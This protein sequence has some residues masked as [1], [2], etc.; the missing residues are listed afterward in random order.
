MSNG[1]CVELAPA[2]RGMPQGL[3]IFFTVDKPKMTATEASKNGHLPVT[4]D[5]WR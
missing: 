1:W 5:Y 2:E 3:Q 4:V